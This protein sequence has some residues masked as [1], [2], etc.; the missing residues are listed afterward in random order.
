MEN[1][2]PYKKISTRSTSKCL[3]ADVRRKVAVAGPDVGKKVDQH[4]RP[5]NTMHMQ[6][7]Q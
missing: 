3:V 1:K 5:S 6:A 7:P 2:D 4:D